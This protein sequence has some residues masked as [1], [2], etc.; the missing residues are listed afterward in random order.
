MLTLC[1]RQLL[2]ANQHPLN[3]NESAAEWEGWKCLKSVLTASRPTPGWTGREVEEGEKHAER[4]RG[5]QRGQRQQPPAAKTFQ[6]PLLI[7]KTCVFISDQRIQKQAEGK[8]CKL[9]AEVMKRRQVILLAV[10]LQVAER[11]THPDPFYRSELTATQYTLTPPT[12][13]HQHWAFSPQLSP[14]C[15]FNPI[16]VLA[17]FCA[18]IMSEQETD[19]LPCFLR[20]MR[21]NKT[22]RRVRPQLWQTETFCIK[23]K[24]QSVL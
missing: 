2:S 7:G 21:P 24:P 11:K 19:L 18:D 20:F 16:N 4:T 10:S 12:D 3:S 13:C 17:L 9:S 23:H 1:Q 6:Q 22:S 8:R 15:H 5:S 14:Q